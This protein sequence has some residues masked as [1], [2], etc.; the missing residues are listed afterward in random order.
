MDFLAF[1]AVTFQERIAL[2][3]LETD[4]DSM[5]MKHSVLNIVFTSLNFALL[6]SR[7]SLYGGIKRGYPLQNSRIRLLEWQQPL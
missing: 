1:L 2:K 3:S 5:R 4:R 7:N 6:S